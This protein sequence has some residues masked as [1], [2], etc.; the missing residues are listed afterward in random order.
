MLL[1]SIV[2]SHSYTSF[3]M[4]IFLEGTKETFSRPVLTSALKHAEQ[5]GN[6]VLKDD[7]QEA[8]DHNFG[9][10]APLEEIPN[11]NIEDRVFWETSLKDALRPIEETLSVKHY[12]G[13]YG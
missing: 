4:R 13:P 1:E 2:N 6:K 3:A 11:G 9:V 12:D 7:I 8:L 5:T 10:D